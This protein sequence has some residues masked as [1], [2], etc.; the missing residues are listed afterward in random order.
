MF[1]LGSTATSFT[2]SSKAQVTPLATKAQ[3]A[4][5]VTTTSQ[6][7]A[8]FSFGNANKATTVTANSSGFSSIREVDVSSNSNVFS[9]N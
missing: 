7:A 1:S 2:P 9:G 4:P 6:T 3:V 8:G 5:L